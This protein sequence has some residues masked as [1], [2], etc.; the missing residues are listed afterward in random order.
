M[1][2][3][4][5]ARWEFHLLAS[6]IKEVDNILADALS[7]DNLSLFLSLHPQASP[8]PAAIPEAVLDLLL[9]RE[10]DWIC[11]HWTSQWSTILGVD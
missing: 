4:I 2:A 7:G 10:P 9:L 5:S 8:S 3:F 11:T 1:H 6:R